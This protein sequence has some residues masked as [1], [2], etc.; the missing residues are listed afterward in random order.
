M[1]WQKPAAIGGGA[2]LLL[3][4]LLASVFGGGGPGKGEKVQAEHAARRTVT[5][6]VKATGEITAETKVPISTKVMGEIV[7]LPVHEGQEVKAGDILVQIERKQ[8]ESARDQAASAL[9]QSEVAIKR[10]QLQLE[11]SKKNL[12][13]AEELKA[14]GFGS[15]TDLESA[16]VAFSS[17]QVELEAQQHAVEQSRSM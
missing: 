7:D 9:S 16:Q 1:S 2:V 14:K 6:R 10:L 15:D 17:A 3:G 8:F 4:I 13:R 12:D 11:V 5:S